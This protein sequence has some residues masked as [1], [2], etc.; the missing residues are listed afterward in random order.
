MNLFSNDTVTW[1][2]TER[3]EI[4][5]FPYP[6]VFELTGHQRLTV[7]RKNKDCR[8]TSGGLLKE[9]KNIGQAICTP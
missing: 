3:R 8:S 5:N 9:E 1:S 7:K 4:K 6:S 2:T